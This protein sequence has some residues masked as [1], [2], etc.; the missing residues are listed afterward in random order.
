M[1]FRSVAPPDTPPDGLKSLPLVAINKI[2]SES[3]DV[4]LGETSAW[5]A[6]AEE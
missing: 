5:P 4:T 3:P 1:E 6:E 2:L